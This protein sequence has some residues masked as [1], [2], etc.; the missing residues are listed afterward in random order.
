MLYKKTKLHSNGLKGV[1]TFEA[2]SLE[3][4]LEDVQNNGATLERGVVSMFYTPKKDGPNPS[5]NIRTD[6]WDVAQEATTHINN[7]FH[8]RIEEQ[9]QKQKEDNA[10]KNAE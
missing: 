4:E 7:E 1:D 3:R 10:T 6:R 9:K 5:A 2:K 8:K